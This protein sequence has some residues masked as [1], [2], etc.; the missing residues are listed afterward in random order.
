V[1]ANLAAVLQLGAGARREASDSQPIVLLKAGDL[2][3]ALCVD[4]LAGRHEIAVKP[5]VPPLVGVRGVTGATVLGDGRV[6]L[7]LDV[8]ALARRC[9]ASQ[10]AKLEA[11]KIEVVSPPE[12]QGPA[13]VM[14]VDDSITV[15][16][17]T[18]RLLERHGLDVMT[19]KDGFEALERLAER[20]P[21]L[22]LLDI[23]MPRMDGFQ[24]AT[25]IRDDA[26]MAHLP[27]IMIS[28]R[29]G[30]K[31]SE[32]ARAIGVHWLLGKPY[33]ESVLLER[34]GNVLGQRIGDG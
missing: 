26:A 22:L 17:V 30:Q 2:K 6:A 11:A 27:I 20:L 12:P 8:A 32:R 5:L 15:R 4:E 33:Q 34:I 19:A 9:V 13:T 10:G 16:R 29:T 7:I 1:L 24:L 25:H 23:E 21:D 3:V 18:Q 14:V 28:S 31:H